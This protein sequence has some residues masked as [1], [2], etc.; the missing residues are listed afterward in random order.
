M[1]DPISVTTT[2]RPVSPVRF[3]SPI[4]QRD[5]GPAALANA[6]GRCE[7]I[8]LHSGA[9]RLDV[10]GQLLASLRFSASTYFTASFGTPW[11]VRVP[12]RPGLARFHLL[13]AGNCSVV[14]EP[15]GLAQT[16]DMSQGDFVIVPHGREHIMSDIAGRPPL[17]EHD[18]PETD[19]PINRIHDIEI[20][21][22]DRGVT[23]LLCGYFL[24][25]EPGNHPLIEALPPLLRV[26]A[27]AGSASPH[28]RLLGDLVS[29]YLDQAREPG[30]GVILSRLADILFVEA[31]RSW[32]LSATSDS[33]ILAALADRNI[34]RA[35]SI[36]HDA[37][38]RRWTV[39]D[40]ARE[41]GQSR[42]AFAQRFQQLIGQPPI[43]YL[44]NWRLSLAKHRLEH[45]Q[46]SVE[47]VAF[48][49]GY[50]SQ[51]AFI[52]AFRKRYGVSPGSIRR[53]MSGMGPGLGAGGPAQLLD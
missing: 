30:I 21:D 25:G 33:G 37:P 28:V 2:N 18:I 6:N 24:T 51:S 22:D 13:L 46:H 19:T 45:G 44:T 53:Q 42:S 38:F 12:S 9:H 10:L 34:G 4:V 27:A 49:V 29:S 48:E 35:L 7:K 5:I 23:R 14:S 47:Q 50:E 8:G 43:E 17:Q 1:V 39:E 31:V 11:S 32:A 36:M 41:T 20:F 26:G 52:R 15:D 16:M 40:L 3:C